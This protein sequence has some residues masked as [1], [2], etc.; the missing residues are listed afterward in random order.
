[1]ARNVGLTRYWINFAIPSERPSPSYQIG[2]GVGVTAF[3]FEGAKR[4]VQDQVF[5]AVPLFEIESV[6][7]NVTWDD[8]EKDH[9]AKNMGV[10]VERGVW[11]PN[12]W[13]SSF[14]RSQGPAVR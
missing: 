11:F 9:V 1:M 13:E 5:Q 12:F 6:V 2:R 3:D 14:E 7:E 4:L 8:L 10:M